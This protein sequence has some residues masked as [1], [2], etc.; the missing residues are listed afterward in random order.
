MLIDKANCAICNKIYNIDN[1]FQCEC[2][3]NFYCEDCS[4]HFE[5]C[6]ICGNEFCNYCMND[7]CYDYEK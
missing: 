4:I 1:M 7:Y 6:D 3:E 2:C 5:S